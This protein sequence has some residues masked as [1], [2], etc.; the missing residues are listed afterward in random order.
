MTCG[1]TQTQR[2]Q[3]DLAS[4]QVEPE[5]PAAESELMDEP[6]ECFVCH[7]MIEPDKVAYY[8]WMNRATDERS[9]PVCVYCAADKLFEDRL[10]ELE[11]ELP[12]EGN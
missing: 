10:A 5:P 6:I 9:M 8:M 11:D 3:S 1:A 4:R 7:K 2:R 12:P